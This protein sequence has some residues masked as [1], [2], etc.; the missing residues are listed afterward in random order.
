M[1]TVYTDAFKPV[2]DIL[3][4]TYISDAVIK[5]SYDTFYCSDMHSSHVML[6]GH[7]RAM[8]GYLVTYSLYFVVHLDGYVQR[9]LKT[10]KIIG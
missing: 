4:A 9:I 6:W 10:L 8:S 2:F 5:S 3:G 7:K 1:V